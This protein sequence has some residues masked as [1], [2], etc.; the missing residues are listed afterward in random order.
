M[1]A[2]FGYTILYVDDVEA[3]L[4]FYERAFGLVRRMLAGEKNYG[5][6]ESGSTRLAFAANSFVRQMLPT[7]IGPSGL[8]QAAPPCELGMVTEDVDAAFRQALAAGAIAVK[9]PETKPWGQMVGYVRD[10]NGFLVE[11]CSELP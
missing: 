10:P 4:G 9:S 8:Q 7:E 11:I 3:S 5:E 2:R 1:N 6:L